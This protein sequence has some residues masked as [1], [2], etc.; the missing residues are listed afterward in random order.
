MRARIPLSSATAAIALTALA[1]VPGHG[2]IVPD[3]AKAS[4]PAAAARL[5]KSAWTGRDGICVSRRWRLGTR[6]R[7]TGVDEANCRVIGRI[8]ADTRE[9]RFVVAAPRSALRRRRAPVV[10]FFHGTS[11]TGEQH[12]NIS[13]WKELADRRGF[14]AVFPSSLGYDLKANPGHR[15]TNVW[16]SIGQ[17]CDLQFQRG[18][19][20]DVAFVRRIHADLDRT[21][22]LDRRRIYAAGFSNG[23]QFVHR[24]AAEAGDIFAA[25]AAW[26][27]V[28]AEG[29]DD[30]AQQCA[31]DRYGRSRHPIPVWNGMGSRDDRFVPRALA[32]LPQRLRQLPLRPALIEQAL[33]HVFSDASLLYSVASTHSR[34]LSMRQLVGRTALPGYSP[35]WSPVMAFEPLQGNPWRNRYL[36]VVLD[37]LPHHYPN[38]RPGRKYRAAT[39]R[40]LGVTM[41][42][43]HYRWLLQNPKAR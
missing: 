18:I 13:R 5:G 11:G 16:N 40:S 30:G 35:V 10:F 3:A 38:A 15:K 19:A 31:A 21:L 9:R 42:E 14:I 27:S 39:S 28:P 23:G 34:E 4:G 22:R 7:A 8:G 26:A 43:L 32:G 2:P 41:A 33:P 1:A 6:Y 20:D 24:L 37:E 36:F 17:A 25:G 29:D 12:W